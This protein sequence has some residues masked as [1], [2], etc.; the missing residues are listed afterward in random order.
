VNLL[1]IIQSKRYLLLFDILF[2]FIGLLY[3][4]FFVNK[5]LVLSDEGYYVHYAERI[6]KGEV[7]YRDFVLQYTPGYFY[8]LA[9]LYKIFGFQILVGR[10]V[11][12]FFCLLI[13]GAIFV[14]LRLYKINSLLI[15]SLAAFVIISLGYPLLFIP[16]VIWACVF[17]AIMLTILY[18]CWYRN[19][20]N[21]YVLWIGLLLSLTILFKQNVGLV[22]TLMLN[23][24]VL[25]SSDQ[26][27]VTRIKSLCVLNSTWIMIIG[28]LILIYLGSAHTLSGL[29]VMFAMS[30]QFITTYPFSYP[31]LSYLF[32][33]TGIFKLLPYY[34][35]IVFAG[36]VTVTLFKKPFEW[37]KLAFS[38]IM[39]SGFFTTVYPAS[40]LLHVYP[41]LGV[42]LV[43]SI[44]FFQKKK[45]LPVVYVL[46][47]IFI[48]MGTY[49]TFFGQ[50]YRYEGYFLKETTPLNL[51]K[52]AN[53]MVDG[54]HS[55][56]MSLLPLNNFIYTHTKKNDHIFVYPFSPMLYFVLD[57]QNPSG[58]SQFVLLEAPSDEYSE[59]RV[60]SEIKEKKVKYIIAVGPY[61][62]DRKISKFIQQQK[63][64]YTTGPYI[65][66]EVKE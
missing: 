28:T 32:Q 52:T 57:R 21:I 64:V 15:H 66:F 3:Y 53:I 59:D 12:V 39:L 9:F 37:E 61:I 24:L 54:S 49:L 6:A 22:F 41:F 51:P 14:L 50:S 33:P 65:V 18:I 2:I 62:Y 58:I 20:K 34:Y 26:K 4:L 8:L 47:T 45:I 5:G 38:L 40:D 25:L 23:I 43:S 60:I 13:L 48:F 19:K 30:K 46:C 16:L 36:F 63:K 31:P 35:P 44:I 11:S 1:K 17:F 56:M 55:T 7:P 29:F 27:L 42:V 10:F